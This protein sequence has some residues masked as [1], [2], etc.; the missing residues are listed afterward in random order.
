MQTIPKTYYPPRNWQDFEN[1]ILDITKYRIEGDFDKYGREGQ[2]QD[3]VDI[4]GRDKKYNS[5]GVQCKYKKRTTASSKKLTTEI[6]NVIIDN[7]IS[8]AEAFVTA[9]DKFIVSTTMFRDTKIQD[10]LISINANR[11]QQSKF[12]VEVWFWETIQ[13]EIS[14]HTEIAYLYY[15]DVL[16]NLNLYN[17]DLHIIS[18]LYKSLYRPAFTTRFNCENDCGNFIQAISDSQQAFVTGKLYDRQGNLIGSSFSS[19]KFSTKSLTDNSK[20]IVRVLQEVR[21]Y[22]TLQLSKG[23]IIQSANFINIPNDSELG[24]SDTLNKR[25]QELFDIFNEMAKEVNADELD[26]KLS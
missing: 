18:L 25:R 4:W 20:N 22:T 19:D 16:K 23:E 10:H 15:T 21:D 13:E 2:S 12:L 26:I 8:N 11:K 9:I 7:E 6:T 5:V 24:I 17:R 3:G 1:L 14:R